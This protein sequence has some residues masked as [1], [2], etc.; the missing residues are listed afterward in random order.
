MSQKNAIALKQSESAREHWVDDI[1]ILACILVVLGHFFQSM[2]EAGIM[3][4]TPFYQWFIQGI[5]LFHVPLFFIC[6]GYLYQRSGTNHSFRSWLVNI[7]KK[8]LALGIPYIIFSSATWI[9]KTVFSGSVNHTAGDSYLGTIFLTPLSPYW[10]LYGLFFIFLF[11]PVFCDRKWA[12][13]GLS[14]AICCKLLS[15]AFSSGIAAVS[16]VLSYEIWFVIGMCLHVSGLLKTV[17]GRKARITGILAAIAFVLLHLG[18][19]FCQIHHPVIDFALGITAC[20]AVI[21]LI[22]FSGRNSQNKVLN[23]MAQYTM[24]VFLMHTMFAAPV[25]I[26]LLKLGIHSPIIHVAAGL[27][28]SFAGP[29]MAAELMR[30]IKWLDFCIY[31][32]KYIGRNKG[33]K[34][35]KA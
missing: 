8:A 24:P 26:L 27:F 30:H 4:T 31:P 28:I 3:R 18:A 9:M 32:T 19:F 12:V 14:A 16:Y 5:Y 22:G 13:I 1:K 21:L 25:R 29:V 6:S 17:N 33:M 15:F 34:S 35:G 7:N 10:Y 20:M 11:T 23:A 2:T